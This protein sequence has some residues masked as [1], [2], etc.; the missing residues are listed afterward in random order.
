MEEWKKNAKEFI[1]GLVVLT[2]REREYLE[3]FERK[4]YK[5]ELLFEDASILENIKDHPMVLW[6]MRQ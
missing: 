2:S 3:A 4:D 5:P 6:K 1:K